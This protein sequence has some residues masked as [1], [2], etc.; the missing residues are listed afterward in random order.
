MR[1]SP[2][3]AR[4]PVP[5]SFLLSLSSNSDFYDVDN[6]AVCL[7]SLII[8][9]LTSLPNQAVRVSDQHSSMRAHIRRERRMGGDGGTHVL[10]KI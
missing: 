3:V 6:L 10:L 2:A 5:F 7:V 4:Q 1:L 9:A 8:F